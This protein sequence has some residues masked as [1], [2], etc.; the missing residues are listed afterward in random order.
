[1]TF[2][3]ETLE[4]PSQGDFHAMN[5]TE[6]VRAIVTR[7]GIREGHALVYYQHTSGTVLIV[8]HEAGILVDL[9]DVLDAIIPPD[10]D[11]THHRRGYDFNGASHLRTAL[12]GVS[13]TIPVV[14][15]DLLMGTYQEI[16]VIDFD[17]PDGIR[18]R[19]VTVQVSGE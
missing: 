4:L 9:Q 18:T 2:L 1:M 13:V 3:T 8:E 14:D 19:R 16:I 10:R 12:L 17:K 11:F 6:R 15:G 7:S 5:I